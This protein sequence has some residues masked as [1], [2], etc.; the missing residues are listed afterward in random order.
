[1]GLSPWITILNWFWSY[2]RLFCSSLTCP[3]WQIVRITW[4]SYCIQSKSY[5]WAIA[6]LYP[7]E[8]Q[9]K[10]LK[11]RKDPQNIFVNF[12]TGK[13]FS[14]LTFVYYFIPFLLLNIALAFG[15]KSMNRFIIYYEEV[16]F[17][18]DCTVTSSFCLL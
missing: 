5:R 16:I 12:S 9:F 4:V 14:I 8:L 3:T 18:K 17:R 10:S 11:W 13:L 1:M 7:M 15:M 2:E 6:S